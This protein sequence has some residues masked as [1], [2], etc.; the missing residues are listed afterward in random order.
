M[1]GSCGDDGTLVR[2]SAVAFDRGH[3]L[4]SRVIHATRLAILLALQ[5]LGAGPRRAWGRIRVVQ[6]RGSRE[7]VSHDSADKFGELELLGACHH[8]FVDRPGFLGLL[9]S[10]LRVS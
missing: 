5:A 8:A 2:H 9:K 3:L 6:A 4:Q 1:T 7:R 10:A